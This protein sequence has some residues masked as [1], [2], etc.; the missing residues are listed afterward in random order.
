LLEEK[1]QDSRFFQLKLT[2]LYTLHGAGTR[3]ESAEFLRVPATW[4]IDRKS[5]DF[6]L[7]GAR[8]QSVPSFQR[9]GLSRQRLVD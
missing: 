9:A 5:V 8:E 1:T 6:V 2:G 4:S 7:A 3:T